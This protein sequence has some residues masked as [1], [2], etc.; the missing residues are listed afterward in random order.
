MTAFHPLRT[1]QTDGNPITLIDKFTRTWRLDQFVRWTGHM[2][3]TKS[4]VAIVQLVED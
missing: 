2:T 4:R 1:Y 3:G